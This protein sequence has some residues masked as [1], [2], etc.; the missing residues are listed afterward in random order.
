MNR[1]L[2]FLDDAGRGAVAIGNP[3]YAKRNGIFVPG[4]GED[5]ARLGFNDTKASWSLNRHIDARC[6]QTFEDT[7]RL[8]DENDEPSHPIPFILIATWNDYEE[9]TAIERGLPHCGDSKAP[10]HGGSQ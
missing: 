4:T 8:F 9:G 2:G 3:D 10:A 1:Y 6:G 5:L 7:L